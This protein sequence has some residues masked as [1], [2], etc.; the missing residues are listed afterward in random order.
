MNES[1]PKA[2]PLTASGEKLQWIDPEVAEE[3]IADYTRGGPTPS[4]GENSNYN[5]AS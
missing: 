4:G 3:V 2:Q 1:T 5:I